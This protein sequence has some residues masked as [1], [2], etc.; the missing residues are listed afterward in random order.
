[1]A[2]SKI[3]IGLAAT[4]SLRMLANLVSGSQFG[5][6]WTSDRIRIRRPSELAFRCRVLSSKAWGLA[7][8]DVDAAR[9]FLVLQGLGKG[10]LKAAD[11]MRCLD[12]AHLAGDLDRRGRVLTQNAPREALVQFVSVVAE[13]S[14]A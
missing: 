7:S 13:V 6:E 1:M 3:E 12:S 5:L 4:L 14:M 2:R 8:L 10:R 9:I 11:V